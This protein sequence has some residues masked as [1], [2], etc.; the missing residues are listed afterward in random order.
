MLIIISERKL[1]MKKA[2]YKVLIREAI[3][4]INDESLLITI[5]SFITGILSN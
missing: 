2:D 3:E 4:K 5:Y 1:H